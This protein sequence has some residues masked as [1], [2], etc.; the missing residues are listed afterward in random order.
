MQSS[1]ALRSDMVVC[2]ISAMMALSKSAR[3]RMNGS[4]SWLFAGA[5]GRIEDL[6]ILHARRLLAE[7]GQPLGQGLVLASAV[8]VDVFAFDVE[9]DDRPAVGR[10]FLDDDLRRVRFA[11]ADRAEDA[12]VARQHALVLALQTQ[13][14]VV[15][16]G[17]GAEH[18]VAG[19]AEQIGDLVAA[20]FLHHG[21]GYAAG[22]CSPV[23]GRPPFRPAVRSPPGCE[24]SPD[25]PWPSEMFEPRDVVAPRG[26]KNGP[27]TIRPRKPV[28]EPR[29]RRSSRID[30]ERS[31]C[32]WPAASA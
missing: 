25:K 12:Q 21:T 6:E 31:G 10:G 11:G 17:D 1:R 30:R 18:H 2:R 13:P 15:L 23:A 4:L 32:G 9:H 27:A 14:D 19:E 28:R 24:T 22:S 16:P 8:H 3:R 7:M 20:Q 5:A 26:E 29:Y